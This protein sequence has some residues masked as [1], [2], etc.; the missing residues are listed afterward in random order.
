[1]TAIPTLHGHGLALRVLFAALLAMLVLLCVPRDVAGQSA[2]R[3][4]FS[5]G[6]RLTYLVRVGRFGNIG[7]GAMWVEGP[8]AVR[9]ANVLLLR[10][11][12][13]AGV[14]PLRGVDRTSS[15]LDA[16][17]MTT[18][19]F[20]KHERHPLS[21]HDESVELFPA[22]LR[23][24]N[25]EGASRAMTTDVPLDELSFMYFLRTLPA[26][27]D[28]TWTFYRHF[29]PAR[30]PTLVRV[31]GR[32]T[33][34][35]TAGAFETVLMEMRVRDPRRYRGEGVIRINFTDDHCRLPVRIESS[36]PVFGRTV[37]TLESHEHGR[38]PCEAR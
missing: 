20:S 35:T 17:A 18:M 3:L 12:L 11:D 31:V 33:I 22:Q 34:T 29:E 26:V 21:R 8:V 14:G 19:R 10:F 15:W 38:V 13:E 2:V 37:L 24:E 7:R 30:N 16:G 9:G 32:E 1:M 25:A 4:P 23:S 5:V 27:V 6:E 28:S 36:M